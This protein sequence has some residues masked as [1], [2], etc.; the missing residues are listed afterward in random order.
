MVRSDT[1]GIVKR[2]NVRQ[3]EKDNKGAVIIKLQ[4]YDI[5]NA[6]SNTNLKLKD[7]QDQLT[8]SNTQ[9]GY[10]IATSLIKWD[11]YSYKF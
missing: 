6:V 1:G 5:I 11:S 8:N 3:Y 10:C 4:N 9:L 7:L 2:I